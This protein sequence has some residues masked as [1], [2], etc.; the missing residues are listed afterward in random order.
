MRRSKE[1]KSRGHLPGRG[2]AL[3]KDEEVPM[4][5]VPFCPVEEG[6]LMGLLDPPN[7]DRNHI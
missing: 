7:L 6:F 1:E 2:A 3:C 4:G 5:R